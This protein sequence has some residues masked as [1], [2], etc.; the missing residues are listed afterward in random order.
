M[1]SGFY[2]CAITFQLTS[3]TVISDSLVCP[4]FLL[5]TRITDNRFLLTCGR[6]AKFLTHNTAGKIIVLYTLTFRRTLICRTRENKMCWDTHINFSFSVT[7]VD[8]CKSAGPGSPRYYGNMQ[9]KE[10][11]VFPLRKFP[12]GWVRKLCIHCSFQ[13]ALAGSR[14]GKQSFRTDWHAKNL[15]FIFP[16][17]YPP[18][19]AYI[20]NPLTP[21]DPYSGRTAPLT[22]KRCILY[23]NSTNTGTEYFKHGIYCSSFS[24]QNAVRFIILTNLVPVVF[25]FYIQGVLKLKKK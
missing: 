22:S 3:T 10:I 2:D 8:M 25:T 16:F 1:K 20:F 9:I 7:D 5:C 19:P 4:Y 24:L 15:I 6:N 21:N 13:P 14:T 23:I 18:P 11:L 12:R 17:D